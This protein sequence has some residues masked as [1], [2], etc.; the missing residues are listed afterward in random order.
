MCHQVILRGD[1]V[2]VKMEQQR[3]E[4]MLRKMNKELELSM[5]KITSELAVINEQL[6]KESA[7]RRQAEENF[8]ASEE[9]YSAIFT[10]IG[11]GIAVISPGEI[12]F[13][14]SVM[15]K[16]NPNIDV[17]S[18]PSATRVSTFPPARRYVRIVQQ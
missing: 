3:V 16:L 11:V 10:H 12:V 8:R 7:E 5:E 18:D 4:D 17:V 14:N 1:G 9:M 13:L 2:E 6:K 15:K